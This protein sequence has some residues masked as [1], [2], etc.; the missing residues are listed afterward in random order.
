MNATI[1][2]E[3]EPEDTTGSED[4][5]ADKA[6]TPRLDLGDEADTQPIQIIK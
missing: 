6:N 5:S 3:V 2:E 1:E 4:L